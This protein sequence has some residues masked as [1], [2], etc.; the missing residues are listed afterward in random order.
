MYTSTYISVLPFYFIFL[1]NQGISER[2]GMIEKDRERE[3]VLIQMK[4]HLQQHYLHSNQKYTT[5]GPTTDMQNTHT[6]SHIQKHTTLTLFCQYI[7][8][9]VC[10]VCLFGEFGG[11]ALSL[12]LSDIMTTAAFKVQKDQNSINTH[13]HTHTCRKCMLIPCITPNIHPLYTSRS[14]HTHIHTL[15]EPSNIQLKEQF[16]LKR[17]F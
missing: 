17:K 8:R 9:S 14:F 11:L 2:K 13:T 15:I 3:R 12:C 4:Y 16:T 6:A 7:E 1:F 5:I 10:E